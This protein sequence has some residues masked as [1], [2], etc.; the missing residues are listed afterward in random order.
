MTDHVRIGILGAARIAPGAVIKPARSTTAAEIVAVAARSRHRAQEFADEHG[1]PR[2]HDTYQELLEDP[3]VDAVYNPLP[4]GL[5]GKWTLAALAAGKHV[6]CE[7]PFTANAAEARQVADAAAA[8]GLVVMEAF[9]YRYH[10][11]ALRLAEIMSSGVLGP[12]R[13]VQ[14]SVCFPLPVFSDIRYNWSL[15]GGALMDAGCYAVHMARLVGG[16]EPEVRSAHALLRDPRIDR[17]MTASL[18]FP[19]GH[20]GTVRASMWSRSLLNISIRAIGE[21]GSV[22]VFNPLGPQFVHRLWLRLQDRRTS[23]TFGKRP[24]YAYQL[25]AFTDA[26]LQG[27]PFPTTPEDAVRNMAVIDA[28]Y[29]AAGLPV[30]EPSA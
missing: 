26:V 10:P 1:I 23:E 4:N 5:H 3:A 6:L 2:V 9:H 27:K 30:R 13:H 14:A 29:T 25:D 11:M 20:T 22:R 15:A 28:I 19:E 16:G 24:T 8:S 21:N 12:L 7:K 17:A 18:R